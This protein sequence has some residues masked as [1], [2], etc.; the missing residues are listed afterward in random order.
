MNAKNMK[1]MFWRAETLAMPYHENEIPMAMVMRDDYEL[2]ATL[3]AEGVSSADMVNLSFFSCNTNAC[4]SAAQL[5]S[6]LS[7][8]VA[9]DRI[10]RE[11]LSACG[12]ERAPK[13]NADGIHLRIGS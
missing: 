4:W 5:E 13:N 10:V 7:A 2:R 8:G 3:R 9:I 6:H 12:K 1:K 11:G